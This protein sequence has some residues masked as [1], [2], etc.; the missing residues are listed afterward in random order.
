MMSRVEGEWRQFAGIAS[1]RDQLY[2]AHAQCSM[3]KKVPGGR[4][5]PSETAEKNCASISTEEEGQSCGRV[6]A[7]RCRC[8]GVYKRE[9]E[10]SAYDVHACVCMHQFTHTQACAS[11]RSGCMGRE[12]NVRRDNVRV[13]TCTRA[14]MGKCLGGCE[15]IH[16][17]LCVYECNK[18]CAGVC[19]DVHA[20]VCMHQFT[21]TLACASRMSG[22]V[23]REE[24]VR[25]DNVTCVKKT[26]AWLNIR[27][28]NVYKCERERSD[29]KLCI[30]KIGGMCEGRKK[31]KS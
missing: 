3:K 26:R 19:N 7:C 31:E 27:T 10:H 24:N 14:C 12:E 16:A 22:C 8:N 18:M 11:R 1:D 29:F 25:R 23:D 4:G 20:C 17:C 15:C 28:K 9:C 13:H 6:G 30:G 2:F 21:H 5:S